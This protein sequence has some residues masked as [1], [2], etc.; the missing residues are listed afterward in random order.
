MRYV[1]SVA[2]PPKI[3]SRRDRQVLINAT[4]RELRRQR[5]GAISTRTPNES[6]AHLHHSRIVGQQAATT[7][8]KAVGSFGFLTACCDRRNGEGDVDTMVTEKSQTAPA[9]A[10]MVSGS[11]FSMLGARAELG[12]VLALADEQVATLGL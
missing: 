8:W 12:R 3:D 5:T 1:A 9:L 6:L 11:Y 2:E 4:S 10:S 7:L